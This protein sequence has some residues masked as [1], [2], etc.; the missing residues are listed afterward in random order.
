MRAVRMR[1]GMGRSF[2]VERAVSGPV[3]L[4]SLAR[5]KWFKRTAG[6]D[7]SAQAA[8][9]AGTKKVGKV[10]GGRQTARCAYCV[11]FEAHRR[12]V[13]FTGHQGQLQPGEGTWNGD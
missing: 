11:A 1:F 13:L 5:P 8:A 4:W 3:P 12:G 7:A 9:A 10:S 6:G 2:P